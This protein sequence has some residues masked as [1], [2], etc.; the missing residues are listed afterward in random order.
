MRR[1]K[2]N[3]R[4]CS[5]VYNENILLL[6]LFSQFLFFTAFSHFFCRRHI[7]FRKLHIWNVSLAG[8]Y[9][10]YSD[11]Y[12]LTTNRKQNWFPFG[13]HSFTEQK[14]DL[15]DSIYW[16]FTFKLIYFDRYEWYFIIT[17]HFINQNCYILCVCSN[18]LCSF[19]LFVEFNWLC[20][21]P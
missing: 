10:K 17:F 14:T 12:V 9:T 4:V 18:S 6:F 1:F 3:I 15:F 21:L 20:C 11:I 7:F 2:S 13:I 8:V 19:V 5:W 16:K